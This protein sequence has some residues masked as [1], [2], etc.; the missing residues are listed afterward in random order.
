MTSSATTRPVGAAGSAN[1]LP[2]ATAGR[3]LQLRTATP[4]LEVRR[5]LRQLRLGGAGGSALTV[6]RVRSAWR[7]GV[8]AFGSREPVHS[9]R[10]EVAD[11]TADGVRVRIYRASEGAAVPAIVWYHGGGF[12]FG[13]LGTADGTCRALA[14]R[15]GACVISVD[16]RLAPEH[17][18]LEARDDCLAAAE[19]VADEA[20]RLGIDPSRIAVA[21]DSAGGALAALV[22]HAW[23]R[24][25]PLLC[26]MLVYP[27]TELGVTYELSDVGNALTLDHEHIE[28]LQEQISRS[29]RMDDPA[30]SPVHQTGTRPAPQTVLLTAGFDYLLAEGLKYARLLLAAGTPVTL[31]HYPGQ[32]H[33]FVSFDRVLAGGVDAVDRLSAV[34]RTIAA[35]EPAPLGWDVRPPYATRRDRWRWITPRQRGRE[36]GVAVKVLRASRRDRG[37]R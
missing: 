21:G 37:S 26:Q 25:T 12:V 3:P 33:G 30:L 20:D 15:T 29:S 11:C 14:N 2:H 16:Y 4:D 6:E 13:G 10:D 24:S 9:T 28:W 34:F 27:A 22:A 19:W 23:R 5:L 18:L 35:G 17:T 36:L 7:L 31:L 1:A 32:M 8:Y